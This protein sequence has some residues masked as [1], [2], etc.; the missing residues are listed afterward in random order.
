MAQRVFERARKQLTAW[1]TMGGIAVVFAGV[2]TFKGLNDYV[3]Q[4]ATEAIKSTTQ[5]HIEELVQKE[6]R[7]QVENLLFAKAYG[8]DSIFAQKPTP[9]TLA[10]Q[11]AEEVGKEAGRERS[12]RERA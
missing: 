1:I 7:H 3:K 12:R 5:S 4:L 6:V 9:A 10:R 2:L 8:P 11:A